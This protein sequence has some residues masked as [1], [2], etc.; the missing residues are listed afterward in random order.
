MINE[1]YTASDL[2]NARNKINALEAYHKAGM[3]N[4]EIWEEQGNDCEMITGLLES[5]VIVYR[6]IRDASGLT[7]EYFE[8]II[9]GV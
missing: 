3:R 6:K 4:R 2:E 8:N 9:S 5:D 1:S 7:S